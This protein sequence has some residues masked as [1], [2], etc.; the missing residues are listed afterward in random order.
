MFPDGKW[1]IDTDKPKKLKFWDWV[2]LAFVV[3]FVLASFF[4][5]LFYFWDVA[6]LNLVYTLVLAQLIQRWILI[7]K[8]TERVLRFVI[9]SVAAAYFSLYGNHQI[10]DLVF[11][12]DAYKKLELF[13]FDG[14]GLYD[15]PLYDNFWGN[16]I[17]Y[18]FFDWLMLTFYRWILPP[19]LIGEVPMSQQITEGPAYKKM[20]PE[21]YRHLKRMRRLD[22]VKGK[23]D[24]VKVERDYNVIYQSC[25]PRFIWKFIK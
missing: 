13:L 15:N 6:F 7:S 16:L 19:I 17:A 4:I 20:T 8:N 18:T 25:L 23:L 24:R 9:A 10:F 21:M 3:Y 22:R 1:K 5:F 12:E 2:L 14:E 11:G